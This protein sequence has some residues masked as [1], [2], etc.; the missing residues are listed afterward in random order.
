MFY[1]DSALWSED[2]SRLIDSYTVEARLGPRVTHLLPV[3]GSIAL[4]MSGAPDIGDVTL[5]T[6]LV[7][8]DD[9]LGFYEY[10]ARTTE[11]FHRHLN[12][13]IPFFLEEQCRLGAAIS[14]YAALNSARLGRPLL[15]W[16]LGSAEGPM[17]RAVAAHARGSVRVLCSS[18]NEQNFRGLRTR[19]ETNVAFEVGPFY[20]VTHGWFN[21]V[22]LPR[23]Y[24]VIF[25]HTSFQMHHPDRLAPLLLLRRRLSG[26]GILLLYEKIMDDTDLYRRREQ[27]K[28]VRF[29][30]RFFSPREVE[31]KK[32]TVLRDMERCQ[33]RL[34]RLT[35]ACR[36]VAR[37][38]CLIWRSG[39]F[40]GI[41][42]SNDSDSLRQ[43][44]ALLPPPAVENSEYLTGLP[45]EVGE[46]AGPLRFRPTTSHRGLP[47]RHAT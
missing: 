8:D 35:A 44:V 41:A 6:A 26:D 20:D 9:A 37:H 40:V 38:V 47:A 7:E 39:N 13:S 33:S 4:G 18:E 46:S 22:D 31:T 29:K 15:L 10:L 45:H 43:F 16:S 1:D 23:R 27:E 34:D 28:D 42:A 36:S 11:T 3:F 21:Q 25:E 30:A 19:P 17:A 2:V 24:D 32:R 14:R 5:D 12:A